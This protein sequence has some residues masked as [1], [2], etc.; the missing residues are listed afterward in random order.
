MSMATMMESYD[1]ILVISLYAYPSFQRKYGVPLPEG[2]YSI[3]AAWQVG[4]TLSTT[5]GMIPGVFA[6]GWLVDRFGY[7]KV[8]MCA[9][10]SLIGLIFITFFAPS[11]EV[12]LVGCL[13]L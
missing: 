13:L 3:P 8:M 4:L 9:H 11:P 10:I 12:L 5:V 1:L 7:R 2:G 6:N